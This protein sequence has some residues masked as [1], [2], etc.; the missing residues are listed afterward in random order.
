MAGRGDQMYESSEVG[1][2][3][4]GPRKDETAGDGHSKDRAI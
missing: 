4:V 3:F 2:G 1:D